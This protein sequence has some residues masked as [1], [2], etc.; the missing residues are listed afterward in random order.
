MTAALVKDLLRETTIRLEVIGESERRFSRQLAPRFKMFEQF[1]VDELALSRC[2]ALLLDPNGSHGQ[3]DLYLSAFIDALNIEAD[4]YSVDTAKIST[5]VVIDDKR[6]IDLLIEVGNWLIG[7]ENKPWAHYQSNQLGDYANWLESRSS[8]RNF[9]LVCLAN[10]QPADE[11]IDTDHLSRLEEGG[12]FRRLTFHKLEKFFSSMA[13]LACALQVRVFVEELSNFIRQR[14]NGIADMTE[15]DEIKQLLDKDSRNME[16]MLAIANAWPRIRQDR[17][18]KFKKDLEQEWKALVPGRSAAKV[19]W[20]PRMD[21]QSGEAWFGFSIMEDQVFIPCFDFANPGL[22]GLYWGVG[23]IEGKIKSEEG[24]AAEVLRELMDQGFSAK[25]QQN[26]WWAWYLEAAPLE[27][28]PRDW[29]RDPR[30]WQQMLNGQLAAE[31]A[32]H[33]FKVYQV[34]GDRALLWKGSM[35]GS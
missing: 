11:A 4:L 7:I 18:E 19:H 31:F 2:I 16:A 29:H 21:S 22:R 3:G 5:E 1:S 13:K 26:P 8:D 32:A 30:P 14:I 33:A 12:N 10:D 15:I 27:N 25:G 24:T 6:R 28:H 23:T 35:E 17:L 34:I 9:V 20:S